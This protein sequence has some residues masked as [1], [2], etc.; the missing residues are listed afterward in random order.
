MTSELLIFM[1]ALTEASK[2]AEEIRDAAQDV[3][4]FPDDEE[5]KNTLAVHC[6]M[7]SLHMKTKGSIDGAREVSKELKTVEK[8]MKLFEDS[9]TN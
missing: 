1:A 7:F 6:M 5:K 4:L 9:S 8:R 2:I 3:L